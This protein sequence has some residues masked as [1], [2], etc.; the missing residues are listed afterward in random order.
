MLLYDDK[1]GHPQLPIHPKRL[2]RKRQASRSSAAIRESHRPAYYSKTATEPPEFGRHMTMSH[3][4]MRNILL[5]GRWRSL[6]IVAI[7]LHSDHVAH[8]YSSLEVN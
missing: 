8:A 6:V 3:A 1:A 7:V 4:F 2:C 5:I